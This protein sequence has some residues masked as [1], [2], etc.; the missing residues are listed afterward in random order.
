M[1]I[2]LLSSVNFIIYSLQIP[3]LNINLVTKQ[4]ESHHYHIPF[5]LKIHIEIK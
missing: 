3:S 4:Q 5:H 1:E 2:Y